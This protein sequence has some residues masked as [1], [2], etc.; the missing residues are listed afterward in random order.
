M[1]N[2]FSNTWVRVI[3]ITIVV[4]FALDQCF[5]ENTQV[6]KNDNDEYLR[7]FNSKRSDFADAVKAQLNDPKSFEFV[8]TKFRDNKN[9]T[10]SLIMEF[11]AKNELGGTVTTKATGE[12]SKATKKIKK[13]EIL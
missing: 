8:E 6:V 1:K 11:R 2:L 10:I 12:F 13:V 3:A 5:N 4:V 7:Y 9:G